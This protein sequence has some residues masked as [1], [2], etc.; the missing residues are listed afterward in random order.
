[1]P[2]GVLLFEAR[3]VSCRQCLVLLYMLCWLLKPLSSSQ[4]PSACSQKKKIIHKERNCVGG[5]REPGESLPRGWQR[6]VFGPGM[7]PGWGGC[8]QKCWAPTR[9]E[10]RPHHPSPVGSLGVKAPGAA[11]EQRLSPCCHGERARASLLPKALRRG[12][13]LDINQTGR[14][15]GS[16]NKLIF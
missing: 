1:M 6:G 10:G 2:S 13:P 7:G 14:R 5:R 12:S 11:L 16:I 3:L 9:A 8:Q 15:R 4:L